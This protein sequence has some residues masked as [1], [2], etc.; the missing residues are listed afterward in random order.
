M[1]YVQNAENVKG[2]SNIQ[3]V[4]NNMERLCKILEHGFEIVP[5][6]PPPVDVYRPPPFYIEDMQNMHK[7][8]N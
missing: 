7:N 4:Q 1:Q 5:V 3:D 6:P 2:T 8:A